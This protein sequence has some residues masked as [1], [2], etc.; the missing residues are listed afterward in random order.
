MRWKPLQLW[1]K[2]AWCTL[3]N[4]DVFEVIK[5]SCHSRVRSKTYIELST[6]RINTLVTLQY[7]TLFFQALL[8]V[9]N[10]RSLLRNPIFIF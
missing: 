4:K 1:L 7:R 10:L 6:E 3:L 2:W 5:F 9:P 8:H